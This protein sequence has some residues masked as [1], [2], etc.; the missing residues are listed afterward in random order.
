MGKT[1]AANVAEKV[2]PTPGERA[3]RKRVAEVKALARDRVRMLDGVQTCLRRAGAA[4]ALGDVAIHDQWI[5]AAENQ[6][7]AY[8]SFVALSLPPVTADDM[9]TED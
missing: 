5:Y 8:K 6:L 9:V 3:E 4:V 2:A 1:V 7:S